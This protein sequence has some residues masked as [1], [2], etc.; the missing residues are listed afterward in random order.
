MF[1]FHKTSTPGFPGAIFCSKLLIYI[2]YLFLHHPVNILQVMEHPIN[3]NRVTTQTIQ[4]IIYKIVQ[5]V[6]YIIRNYYF[7][8]FH[9]PYFSLMLSDAW[10]A[11]ITCTSSAFFR[12]IANCSTISSRVRCLN[13]LYLSFRISSLEESRFT[14]S[15]SLTDLLPEDS[16]SSKQSL[17][18]SSLHFTSF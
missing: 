11:S 7:P 13:G 10:C 4:Q 5:V 2:L 9:K 15:L 14:N 16:A 8:R 17:H 3:N 18:M 12:A 6:L 1:H